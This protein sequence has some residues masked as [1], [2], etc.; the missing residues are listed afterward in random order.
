M[1][2][3]KFIYEG[4]SSIPTKLAEY[5]SDSEVLRAAIIAEY[6]AINLYLQMAN[7]V[8]NDKIKSVLIDIA[9]EEKVHVG[10]FEELL[11]RIDDSH[12]ESEKKGQKEI[13]ELL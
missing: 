5:T 4:M 7:I 6:D 2:F 1:R 3:K 9:K 12:I 13:E 11:R 8:K 10:E